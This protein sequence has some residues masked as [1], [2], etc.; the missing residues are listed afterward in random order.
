VSAND[1][2][3]DKIFLQSQKLQKKF[4]SPVKKV[5]CMDNAAMIGILAYFKI[6]YNK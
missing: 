6:K 1:D 3:R 4:L 5:F 2:L